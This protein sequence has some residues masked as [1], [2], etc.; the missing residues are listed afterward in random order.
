MEQRFTFDQVAA[1]YTAARPD[2]PEALV[3][4]VVS[5]AGLS[6]GDA[7]LEIGCGSGQATKSFAT[8]G[9]RVLA[10]DPGTALIRAARESL[11]KFGN[12]ALLETTFEAWPATP[13]AFRLVAAAQSWHWVSRD[14]R[15][16][17]AAEVLAPGGT[18]AVFGNVPVGLP[19]SLLG[20]FKEIYLR[21]TGVW[22]PPPEAWYLPGGP[23][24]GELADTGVFGPATHKAYPWQR[25]YTTSSYCTFLTTRSDHRMLAP[26]AREALLDEV[27]RS[28][29]KH[30]GAFEIDYE[31]HLYM[32]RRV[33]RA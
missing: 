30:G 11:A 6:P 19:A 22:G 15:L 17:K 9:F 27:A 10:I 23:L 32:C 8:R 26:P 16:A 29:D 7:V 18:L 24:G 4:D 5:F 12:V 13:A 21:R 2:Y 25:H 28:I 1:A 3:D 14:M 33:D 31:T 20:D